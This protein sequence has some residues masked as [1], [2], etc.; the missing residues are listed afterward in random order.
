VHALRPLHHR[1]RRLAEIGLIGAA[2]T[3]RSRPISNAAVTS[4][5]QG[6]VIDLC[7]VGALTSK[8]YAFEAR[9]WELKKTESD[10][11]H[12]RRRL[13][14][15]RRHRGREVLRVLPRVNEAST[16]SGSRT[17]PASSVDGLRRSAWTVPM[18]ASEAA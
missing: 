7:P 2:K 6:N 3:L 14:D 16:K 13:G 15:P 9:P 17:R 18:S 5:L 1:S 11:R 8:P 12:G 4:E 10:R